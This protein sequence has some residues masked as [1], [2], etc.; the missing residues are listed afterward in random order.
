MPVISEVPKWKRTNQFDLD[1][2]FRHMRTNIEFMQFDEKLQVINI[3]STV[4]N[5]G[6]STIS[7]NLAKM[8]A[9]KYDKVLL[10][11]CDL[12]NPSTHSIMGISNNKGLTNLLMELDSIKSIHDSGYVQSIDST[13]S[14]YKLSVLTAGK[15][16]PN[17]IEVLSSSRFSAFMEK[18]K[19][20]YDYVLIDCPPVGLVADAIPV[21]NIADG[22]LFVVSCDE[23]CKKAIKTSKEDLERN[24]INI[25]GVILN[26]V[27]SKASRN[28]KGYGYGYYGYGKTNEE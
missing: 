6:K 27:D 25:V 2:I 26:N 8:Y 7:Y 3:T 21:S 20:E 14:G 13:S 11:D 22:T 12:R 15:S 10:L 16:I 1:E 23:N 18:A 28:R 9:A 17:P 5:E 19:S 4:K 24:G